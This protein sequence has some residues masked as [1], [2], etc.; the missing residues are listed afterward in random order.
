MSTSPFDPQQMKFE[1]PE[2]HA[3]EMY[4]E[5]DRQLHI[6]EVFTRRGFETREVFE[7][8]K[9]KG[10][11][12]ERQSALAITLECALGHTFELRLVEPWEDVA[13]Y[14]SLTILTL[15]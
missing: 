14:L 11:S 15:G 3:H 13:P 5:P 2:L 10:N 8:T 9:A 4:S 7:G 12:G 1:C 6:I